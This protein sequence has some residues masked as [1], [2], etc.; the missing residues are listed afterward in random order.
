MI[1][2]SWSFLTVEKWKN[3]FFQ[4]LKGKMKL[5]VQKLIKYHS[6]HEVGWENLIIHTEKLFLTNEIHHLVRDQADLEKFSF[7]LASCSHTGTG[8]CF[9]TSVKHSPFLVNNSLEVGDF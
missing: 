1:I 4:D 2:L 8:F 9:M 7:F 5:I 3:K 6:V